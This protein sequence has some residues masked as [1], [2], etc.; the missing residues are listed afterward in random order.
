MEKITGA[1]RGWG[2]GDLYGVLY[3]EGGS[4]EAPFIRERETKAREWQRKH[5][6]ETWCSIENELYIAPRTKGEM[7]KYAQ[8]IAPTDTLSCFL[9]FYFILFFFL[10][11][12]VSRIHA[13]L[14]RRVSTPYLILHT[15]AHGGLCIRRRSFVF[16]VFFFSHHVRRIVARR[17]TNEIDRRGSESKRAIVIDRDTAI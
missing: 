3:V 17:T 15:P 11:P 12:L 10:N 6:N 7:I 16:H 4:Y 9:L 8:P 13:I 2:K 5:K 1:N 14:H